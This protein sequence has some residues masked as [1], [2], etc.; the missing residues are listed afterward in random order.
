[1]D[2]QNA[3]IKLIPGGTFFTFGTQAVF[4]LQTDTH[5]CF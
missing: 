2:Q 5:A 4:V 3:K 1:M